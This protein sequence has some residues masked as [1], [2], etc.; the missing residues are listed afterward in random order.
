MKKKHHVSFCDIILSTPVREQRALL[1]AAPG[2]V[3]RFISEIAHNIL[4]GHTTLSAKYKKILKRKADVIRLL[5]KPRLKT[6]KRQTLCLKHF[7]VVLLILKSC[8]NELKER[9]V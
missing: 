3:F 9:F 8:I 4:R 7:D 5:S 2:E 6:G 1:K